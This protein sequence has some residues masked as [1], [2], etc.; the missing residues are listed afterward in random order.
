VISEVVV[1]GVGEISAGVADPGGE[2]PV[3]APEP[4]VAAPESPDGEDRG[5]DLAAGGATGDLRAI[6]GVRAKTGAD[7]NDGPQ[8]SDR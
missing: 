1:G 3:E 4:G 6:T 2:D 7:R 5:L 8:G